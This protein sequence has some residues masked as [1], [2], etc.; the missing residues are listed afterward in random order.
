[1]KKLIIMLAVVI[2]FAGCADTNINTAQYTPVIADIAAPPEPEQSDEDAT[3]ELDEHLAQEFERIPQNVTAVSAGPWH[4]LAV[5][6]SGTLWSWGGMAHPWTPVI[7]GDG[8]T[9]QRLTPVLIMEDVVSAAAGEYHSLAITSDNTLWAWGQNFVGQLGD[10]TA[11]DRLSPVPIMDGVVY[12]AIAPTTANSSVM[13]SQRNFAITEDGTLW[14]WGQNGGWDGMMGFLGDGTADGG[15]GSIE[16]HRPTPVRIMDDVIS[17]V[18]TQAGGFAITSGNTL[19][20][21]GSNWMGQLG[22]GTTEDRLAP[23]KI[24]ENIAKTDG[25]FA[26]TR[27]G[28]LWQIAAGV[29]LN[30]DGDGWDI[31]TE[32]IHIM[33]NAAFVHGNFA[34]DTDNRL[35]AWGENRRL[36]DDDGWG[37]WN[38]SLAPPVGDGTMYPRPTPV[39]VMEDV[40]SF[41]GTADAGFA[42]G[43]DGTLWG[44]GIN[45]IG[46]LGDGTAE[47]RLAPVHILDNVVHVASN[48]YMSHWN[49]WIDFVNTFAVTD[50]GA[51]W[52]WGGG[53]MVE[54]TIGDGTF[55]NHLVP[56]LIIDSY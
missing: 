47:P 38:R 45:R 4:T 55:E 11:E 25:R 10:G 42:I 56:I 36:D 21:W 26:I 40:V 43:A 51:L 48:Y 20:A 19:W 30:D 41:S 13:E 5:T 35:W 16:G 28:V 37:G 15:W 33:D 1:M 50:C 17:V 29:T 8:T 6:E 7:I 31:A 52:A 2:L 46:Q 44:W 3:Q 54:V 9:E 24:K 53:G 32:H 39:V 49:G 18:P 14:G 27:D 12:A 22:D 23:V 34:I